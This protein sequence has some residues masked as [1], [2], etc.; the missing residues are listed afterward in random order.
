[1]HSLTTDD[2]SHERLAASGA[3][4]ESG[5]KRFRLTAS[6]RRRQNSD[7]DGLPSKTIKSTF[8][9]RPVFAR[10]VVQTGR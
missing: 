4:I 5:I 10:I 7:N 3:L 9:Q 2:R 1:L 8:Y 6:R